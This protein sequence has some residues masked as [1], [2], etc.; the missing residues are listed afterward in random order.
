MLDELKA[1]ITAAVAY[2]MKVY[3]QSYRWYSL[4]GVLPLASSRV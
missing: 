1:Q 2:V 4:R 3:M